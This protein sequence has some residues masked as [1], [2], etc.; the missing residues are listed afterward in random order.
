MATLHLL[1]HSPFADSR[2]ASCLQLLSAEDALLLTGDAVYA[3][4]TGTAQRQALELM[5]VSIALFALE[6][7]VV[8]RGLT[9]LPER[10]QAIDYACFVELCCRYDRTNAWL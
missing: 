8:A 5:P 2:L 7:D 9:A 6:E 1:S 4:Q 10:L 3:L